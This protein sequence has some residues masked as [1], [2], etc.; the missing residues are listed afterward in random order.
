MLLLYRIDADFVICKAT[1]LHSTMLLLYRSTAKGHYSDTPNLHSTMLLLYLCILQNNKQYELNLHSTM[2]L[3][4]RYRK[5][6]AGGKAG[7]YIPLCFYFIG[8][9]GSN[10]ALAAGFTFHYASTLSFTRISCGQVRIWIYIPLCFYFIQDGAA[11]PHQSG[12]IY[13]P[14]CFYFIR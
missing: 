6:Q 13:I 11:V 12:R 10:A 9:A 3:L 7:I 14:L 4:Y 2:L 8:V 5:G 1:D